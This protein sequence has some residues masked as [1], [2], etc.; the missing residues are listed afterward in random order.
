MK[1]I[2]SICHD[3]IK[4][5]MIYA[6]SLFSFHYI[7]LFAKLAIMQLENGYIT[8]LFKTSYT[9]AP[10][11]VHNN[12]KLYSSKTAFTIRICNTM[13]L[14]NICSYL[15]L[16]CYSYYRSLTKKWRSNVLQRKTLL[17][18]LLC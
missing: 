18:L 1:K 11:H 10:V 8:R 14:C 2:N 17:N 13:L 9:C 4:R 15:V 16:E 3:V 12:V 6:S 7:I 5:C